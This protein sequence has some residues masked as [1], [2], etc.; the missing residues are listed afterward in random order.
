VTS[1]TATTTTIDRAEIRRGFVAIM[2]LWL[3]SIPFAFA[4]AVLARE[5]GLTAIETWLLSALV[6]GGAAQLAFIDL[7][8]EHAA[9]IVILGTVLLLNLRH[10]LYGLSLNDMMP[11]ETTP[12]RPLLAH[13]LTDEAFGLTIREY[14]DGRGS[15]AFFFGAGVSLYL[16]F[17]VAT[18]VGVTLS[19]F[20]PDPER[21]GL[22]F[23]FP[24]SYLAIL[25]PL[26]RKRTDLLVAAA[27]G[28]LALTLS[29]VTSG[30]ITVLTSTSAAAALGAALKARTRRS[31]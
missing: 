28:C 30:G 19:R 24:L 12:K 17:I 8:G 5:R 22:D 31:A 3:G 10:I 26:L 9:S 27:G 4:F 14:R 1:V 16:C 2:P 25:L 29:R 13:I 18:L 6:F 15:P 23:V 21:I 11:A 7:V 20:I